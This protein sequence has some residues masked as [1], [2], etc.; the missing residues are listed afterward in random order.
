MTRAGRNIRIKRNGIYHR[1]E[2][3]AGFIDGPFSKLNPG[4]S[5]KKLRVLRINKRILESQRDEP[6][7]VIK[8]LL[9]YILCRNKP[10]LFFSL[11]SQE[12]VV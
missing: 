5:K 1:N 3:V 12:R 2:E 11:S 10:L 8:R 6:L 7:E 9:E 4:P